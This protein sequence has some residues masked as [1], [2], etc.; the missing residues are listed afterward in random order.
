MKDGGHLYEL[1]TLTMDPCCPTKEF[2]NAAPGTWLCPGC[3]SAKSGL[4]AIDVYLQAMP[5]K[6]VL[7]F[8]WGMS[9]GIIR[10]DF[11][12]VLGEEDVAKNLMLGRVLD[13][14]GREISDFATFRGRFRV[15]I[16]GDQRSRYRQCDIC[17]RHIYSPMGKSYILS[18]IPA[19][20]SIYESGLSDLIVNEEIVE[21]V[22]QRKWRELAILKL[23]VL[24]APRDDKPMFNI[25]RE[26]LEPGA[27]A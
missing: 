21:R 4:G 2:R 24:D 25:E 12:E 23:P 16:R 19:G 18:G 11:I 3:R 9:I 15:V 1:R 14:F 7:N 5:K 13:P 27:N 20:F 6:I 8:V 26:W 17:G 22:R 10:R